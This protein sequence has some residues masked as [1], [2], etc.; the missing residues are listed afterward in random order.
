MN[1]TDILKY[2]LLLWLAFFSNTA[3]I[4]LKI[5]ANFYGRG[6]FLYVCYC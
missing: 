2:G 4:P 6:L 5:P 3:H 1:A